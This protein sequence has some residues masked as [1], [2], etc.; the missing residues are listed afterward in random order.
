MDL[1]EGSRK[2][3]VLVSL[4]LGDYLQNWQTAAA[5]TQCPA[6]QVAG[7]DVGKAQAYITK[8]KPDFD[9]LNA[10][11]S[12]V[13][14]FET[15]LFSGQNVAYAAASSPTG[16]GQQQAQGGNTNQQGGGQQAGQ[17]N[18]NQGQGTQSAGTP[19]QGTQSQAPGAIL[20][21]I[22][23]AD[24][25]AQALGDD[26]KNVQFLEVHALESGGSQLTKSFSI[27][28]NSFSSIHFS[29]G[30]VATFAL[31]NADGELK[32]GGF[33]VS[34]VGWVTPDDVVSVIESSGKTGHTHH[35]IDLS[36]T[37]GGKI[38]SNSCK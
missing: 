15:G 33:A 25:L 17:N 3:A 31:F 5:T 27:I 32:C 1:L 20:Q 26:I 18:Q 8:W 38:F 14:T 29:G 21:Q 24:L 35:G 16:Q 4:E 12:A 22:L 30:S 2:K 9:L 6:G 37:P 7:P 10:T 28:G 13:D 19:T 23:P 36:K 11:I 34:Y